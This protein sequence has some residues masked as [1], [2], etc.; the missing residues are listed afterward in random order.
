MVN[1]IIEIEISGLT[2]QGMGVGRKD[3]LAVFVADTI[4]GETVRARIVRRQKNYAVAERL[5][6]LQPS[7]D[8]L[9][10]A[11]RYNGICGGCSLQHV[12]YA[13]QLLL[14]RN[15]VEDTLRRIGG[16]REI[17]VPRLCLLRMP[18]FT[19]TAPSFICNGRKEGRS[20][21]FLTGTAIGSR[22]LQAACYW[23]LP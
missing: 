3:G 6:V 5:A 10:P 22:I 15:L 20:S 13:R 17:V 4:P 12:R 2:H 19:A 16:F 18:S 14:K 7:A 21:V 11:C 23:P 8:R 9:Q 1:E